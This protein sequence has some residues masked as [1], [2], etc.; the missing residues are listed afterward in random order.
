[1]LV[2][3]CLA[4]EMRAERQRMGL[5]ENATVLLFS[6]E[7]DTDPEVYRRIVKAE[8]SQSNEFHGVA[9]ERP[10]CFFI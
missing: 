10:R 9:F 1:M 6:T 3:L 4:P 5:D 2:H 7:G 8:G